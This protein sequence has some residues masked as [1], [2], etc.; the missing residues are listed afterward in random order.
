LTTRN[1]L[2]VQQLTQESFWL[3][4]LQPSDGFEISAVNI[5]LPITCRT[6]VCGHN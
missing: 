5:E 3:V 2:C 4:G 6:V 1:K